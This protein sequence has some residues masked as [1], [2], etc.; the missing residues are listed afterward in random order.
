MVSRFGVHLIRVDE[1]RQA[2]LEGKQE[3]EQARTLLRE[4]RYDRAFA[5]WSSELR[6]VAYVEL[7]EPPQ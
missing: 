2:A 3:R 5:E 6:A 7:R 4:E 1:R